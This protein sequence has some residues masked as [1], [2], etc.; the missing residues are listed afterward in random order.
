[1][2]HGMPL[3]L[4]PPAFL[5]TTVLCRHLA[6]RHDVRRPKTPLRS[7]AIYNEGIAE[8]RSRPSRGPRGRSRRNCSRGEWRD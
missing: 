1:M 7:P 6:C 8:R 4:K 3:L 5:S 2:S